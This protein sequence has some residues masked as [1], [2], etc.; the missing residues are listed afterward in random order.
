MTGYAEKLAGLGELTL[1]PLDPGAHAGLVHGWVTQPRNRFWGMADHTVAE[2]RE[3]YE[4]VDGLD[5]HH[6]YLIR[7]DEAPIGIFQTYQPEHDPV[8]ECYPVRPGDF[9]IHLM[10]SAG[11]LVLPHL[12]SVA[13]PALLRFALRDPAHDRIVAEPDVRNTKAIRR[14]EREG[15]SLGP[16]IDL[17][18]KRAR[19]V[20]LTR[21]RFEAG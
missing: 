4:F 15:F 8:G 21:E 16:Q 18:H 7:I 14:F 11:D 10:L 17:G 2:V 19:L 13:I 6:A 3:I 9:G 20:F 12:S 5:T 1:I